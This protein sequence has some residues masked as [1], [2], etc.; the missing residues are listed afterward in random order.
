MAAAPTTHVNCTLDTDLIGDDSIKCE[1]GRGGLGGLV[2]N[3]QE[4]DCVVDNRKPVPNQ[5]DWASLQ[6]KLPGCA[7]EPL[8]PPELA[9]QRAGISLEEAFSLDQPDEQG[10]NMYQRLGE[11]VFRRIANEFYDRVYG[12]QEKWFTDVFAHSPK[13][14]AIRNN[15]EFMV[16]RCGGPMLYS[17]RKGHPALPRRHAPFECTQRTADRYMHHMDAALAAVPELSEDDRHKLHNYFL[18]TCHFLAVA[19]EMRESM[20]AQAQQAQ[21]AAGGQQGAE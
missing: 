10:R 8:S 15:W 16:Q 21:Q 12:D 18:H 6:Q 14:V 7:W 4:F 1:F 2:D 9:A 17:Q 13:P 19:Q 11:E 5:C 3:A 20:Q